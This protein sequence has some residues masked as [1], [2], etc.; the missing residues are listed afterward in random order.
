V[1]TCLFSAGTSLSTDPC[2][3][4]EFSHSLCEFIGVS[5]LMFRGSCF[6]GV[7][8]PVRFLQSFLLHQGI[9]STEGKD[10]IETFYLLHSDLRC[11]IFCT[12]SS[13][14]LLYLFPSTRGEVYLS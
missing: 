10:L 12:M 13:C 11:L 4:C 6:L 8:Y 3:P 5:P 14:G 7:L 2:R 9:L 1:F